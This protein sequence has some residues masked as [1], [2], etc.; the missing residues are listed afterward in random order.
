M[1]GHDK[2]WES[3][4]E[5]PIK[6]LGRWLDAMTASS[7]TPIGGEHK[8]ALWPVCYGGNFAATR[9]AILQRPRQLWK[10]M[11]RSLR[12]GPDSLEEGHFAER[13][14]AGLLG[15][16]LTVAQE[17]KLQDARWDVLGKGTC[18]HAWPLYGQLLNKCSYGCAA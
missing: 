2:Y 15:G 9:G 5:S 11:E 17:A 4:F 12:R 14:W 13:S 6:P 3:G 8:D 16:P 7:K 18:L 1:R 10:A